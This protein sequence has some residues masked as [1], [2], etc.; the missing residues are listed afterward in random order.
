MLTPPV[1]SQ[2]EVF[3][4]KSP[5]PGPNPLAALFSGFARQNQPAKNLT[6]NDF[7]VKLLA[8][9]AIQNFKWAFDKYNI[10]RFSRSIISDFEAKKN[11][12]K[13]NGESKSYLQQFKEAVGTWTSLT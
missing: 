9:G 12:L 5:P 13:L 4:K 7:L 3:D 11:D 6:G 2:R 1:P 8:F 10:T